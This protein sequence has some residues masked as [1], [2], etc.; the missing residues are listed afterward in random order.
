[1]FIFHIYPV[2]IVL[3]FYTIFLYT[4]LPS[5][6]LLYV[7]FSFSI[8]SSLSFFF[9]SLFLFYLPF[10]FAFSLFFSSFLPS[11]FLFS[12]LSSLLFYFSLFFSYI[13]PFYFLFLSFSLIQYLPFLFFFLS[14]SLFIIRFFAPPPLPPNRNPFLLSFLCSNAGIFSSGPCAHSFRQKDQPLLNLPGTQSSCCTEK[15]RVIKYRK[16]GARVLCLNTWTLAFT[17]WKN[18][19]SIEYCRICRPNAVAAYAQ[20]PPVYLFLHEIRL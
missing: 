9:F 14:F 10:L 13:I 16:E 12:L 3:K 20:Y 15:E 4:F 7:Q 19:E 6:S 1:L 5:I 11:Y 2:N 18:K 17:R 8:L